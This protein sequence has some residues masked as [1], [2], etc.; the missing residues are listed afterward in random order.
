MGIGNYIY[1][2]YT[3]KAA[4]A[5][6]S[7]VKFGRTRRPFKRLKE[8]EKDITILFFCK[9]KDCEYVEDKIKDYFKLNFKQELEFGTE[10]YSGDIKTMINN[11]EDIINTLDQKVPYDITR[12][13]S[14]Y[15]KHCNIMIDAHIDNEFD[16]IFKYMMTKFYPINNHLHNNESNDEILNNESNDEIYINDN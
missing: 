7:I 12:F 1:V 6:K 14:M 13:I 16:D 3:A 15:K 9:V 4:R 10:Y 11:I 8:Y 5:Q 2:I